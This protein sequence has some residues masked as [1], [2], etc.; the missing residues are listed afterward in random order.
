MSK[1]CLAGMSVKQF[2]LHPPYAIALSTLA[3]DT[4]LAAVLVTFDSLETLLLLF[5]IE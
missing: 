4:L 3:K 5:C 1:I 2:R